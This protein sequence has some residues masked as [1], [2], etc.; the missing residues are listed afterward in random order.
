M[1][2]DREIAGAS[3]LAEGRV[4][5]ALGGTLDDDLG[6]AADKTGAELE[7]VVGG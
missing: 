4:G 5:G 6:L 3:A 2:M 1:E 7:A